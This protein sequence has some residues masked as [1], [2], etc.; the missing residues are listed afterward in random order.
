MLQFVWVE[1]SIH[2]IEFELK[3]RGEIVKA[4]QFTINT[5]KLQCTKYVFLKNRTAPDILLHIVMDWVP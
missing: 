3:F 1:Y 2:D 5:Y 4:T